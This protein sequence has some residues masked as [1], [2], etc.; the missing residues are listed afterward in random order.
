MSQV[1]TATQWDALWKELYP[2]KA[3]LDALQHKHVF[4]SKVRK[5]GE[6]YGE[7]IPVPVVYGLPSGRSAKIGTVLGSTN[8]PIGPT[9]SA[10]FNVELA[11]DYAGTWI[12]ELTMKKAS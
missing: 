2:N 10:R 9:R 7:Y 6:A 12:D 8:S 11:S 1:L 4:M 3:A 5:Q